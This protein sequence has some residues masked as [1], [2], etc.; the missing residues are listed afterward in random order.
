MV[1]LCLLIEADVSI[2]PG[3]RIRRFRP[4]RV[5]A[6]FLQGIFKKK[7]A[8]CNNSD[9]AEETRD[10]SVLLTPSVPHCLYY[11]MC[12]KTVTAV[13]NGFSLCA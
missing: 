4:E 9:E 13:S 3:N 6:I 7:K 5:L 11:K 1:V 12:L 2:E 10:I 8:S